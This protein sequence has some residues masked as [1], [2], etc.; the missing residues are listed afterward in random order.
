MVVDINN[1]RFFS[2]GSNR[3]RCGAEVPDMWE[4]TTAFFTDWKRRLDQSILAL[5]DAPLGFA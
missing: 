3:I 2:S 4:H 5:E 1:G